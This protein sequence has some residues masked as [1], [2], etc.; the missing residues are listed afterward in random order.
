MSLLGTLIDKNA[1]NTLTGVTLTT[2]NHSLGTTPDLTL[3]NLRSALSA[4]AHGRLYAVGANA[5]L[6]TV[7]LAAASVA[8]GSNLN[9]FDVW[10]VYFHSSI[11]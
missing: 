5:S 9:Y 4:T 3:T 1:G 10:N 2:Y 6:S 11:R 8:L 7:G